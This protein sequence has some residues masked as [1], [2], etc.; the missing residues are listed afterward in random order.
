MT[1]KR[2]FV[3]SVAITA[4]VAG[5]FASAMATAQEGPATLKVTQLAGKIEPTAVDAASWKTVP[6]REIALD[7]APPVHEAIS[8]EA[9]IKRIKVQAAR[10]ED[11]VFFRLQW[12]DKTAETKL[13]K[14]DSFLDGVA[15]QFAVDRDRAT[16]PIMGG[17]GK[18]VNIWHWSAAANKGQNL[19]A[20]GFGTLTPLATQ[21]VT[22]TGKYR[23]GT[24]TVIFH[25]PVKSTEAQAVNLEGT[26]E[27]PVAF[28]V[29]DGANQER[30]GLKAVNAEWQTLMF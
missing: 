26:G 24:W 18:L 2:L 28:A 9:A 3:K 25:R 30:D 21:D 5:V 6:A 19:G 7:T 8:G 15:I 29:W 1:T 22:A 23:N 20:N 11:G 12:K 4:V 17:E 10:N 16:S 14:L 13:R 27:W